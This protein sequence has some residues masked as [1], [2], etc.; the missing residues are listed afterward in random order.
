MWGIIRKIL[1]EGSKA[2]R[3]QAD[4]IFRRKPKIPD[5]AKPGKG[6]TGNKGGKGARR[7]CD[8]KNPYC[9]QSRDKLEKSRNSYEKLRDEHKQKLAH[10]QR[11]PLSMDHKGTYRNAPTPDARQKIF[12]GRARALEKQIAKHESELRKIN[13]ALEVLGN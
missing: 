13:E 6:G 11:D 5:S 7:T 2:A 9:G 1:I 10:W 4:K 3:R 12:E 8:P